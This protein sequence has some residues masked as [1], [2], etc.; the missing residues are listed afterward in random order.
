MDTVQCRCKNCQANLA[1]FA[2]LWTQ[3][4]KSYFSP[5]LEAKGDVKTVDVEPIRK[6]EPQ[7][8]VAECELKDIACAKCQQVIGIKCLSS[9]V[10][11]VFD[12]SQ[13]LLRQNSVLFLDRKSNPSEL[14]VRRT[15][16]LRLSEASRPGY[17]HDSG[18]SD[19]HASIASE[20]IDL[21]DIQ[22]DLETQREDIERIDTAGYQVVSQ[23]N[24]TITRID[25]EVKKLNGAMMNLR[26]DIDNHAA[27]M[28][29]V[30]KDVAS[31]RQSLRQDSLTSPLH[32]K[33]KTASAAV[34]EMGKLCQDAKVETEK[35][36]QEVH[37]T[38]HQL[39]Q[40][41]IASS[42]LRQE[43]ASARK[44]TK[45][46][47]G[48]AK[49]TAKETA[50]LRMEL[51]KLKESLET[52]H[53]KHDPKPEF[54]M[55]RELDILASNITKI[56]N[57]ANQVESLQM[58]LDLFK[59]R[60]QRLEASVET[61]TRGRDDRPPKSVSPKTYPDALGIADS[62]VKTTTLQQEVEA[63]SQLTEEPMPK[64]TQPQARKRRAAP[65]PADDQGTA[66]PKLTK[67]GAI[68]KRRTKRS[69]QDLSIDELNSIGP[70]AGGRRTRSSN[71]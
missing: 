23:F 1:K 29:T 38:K 6:G 35:L 11:H 16:D 37:T 67:S 65:E 69:K 48:I 5:V 14:R 55:P 32:S 51:A 60:V 3:I 68:D 70:P 18:L 24:D 46:A 28:F 26:R 13:I 20:Y 61:S 44:A 22:A 36:N 53:R 62:P 42:N 57:R 66:H 25:R 17:C 56:G 27:D 63:P 12:D 2:N 71:C 10:N 15:L 58:E 39:Q 31:M 47:L 41:E 54:L 49:D 4:G 19:G 59:S 21:L 34:A 52:H 50:N 45:D 30:K 64:A 43:L 8:L 7:T 33:L 9:P 40:L